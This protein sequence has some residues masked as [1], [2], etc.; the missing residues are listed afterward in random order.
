MIIDHNHPREFK[1]LT[2]RIMTSLFRKRP[3]KH[4]GAAF[5]S[6]SEVEQHLADSEFNIGKIQE[7]QNKFAG[8]EVGRMIYSIN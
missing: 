4:V 8:G 2:R 3:P 6:V 5:C 1:D 7:I